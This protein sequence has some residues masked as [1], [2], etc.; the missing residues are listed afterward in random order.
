[1][2]LA[3]DCFFV[4]LTECPPSADAQY[5]VSKEPAINTF[6]H[7]DYAEYEQELMGRTYA[8]YLKENDRG[9]AFNSSKPVA[10]FTIANSALVMDFLQSA[11]RNKINQGVPRVKQRRQYPAL[12][13]CQL[14][15]FDEFAGCGLGD[16]L[17]NAIKDFALMLNETTA[18]HYLIVEA[19]NKPKVLDFYQRNDFS[20]LYSSEEVELEKT[21]RKTDENGLLK[22][23]LMMYDMML[24]M[25]VES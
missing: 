9:E 19:V 13:I 12:L 15:V 23:R 4:H 14:A 16:E 6:F 21:H 3:D 20:L 22:T 1:M 25:P 11:R 2:T 24:S 17:L 7:S 8:F 18:C 10:A 5:S